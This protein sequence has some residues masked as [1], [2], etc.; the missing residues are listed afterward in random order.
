[1]KVLFASS[2]IFPYAKSGG[3]ADVADA[4]PRALSSYTELYSVIPLYG[5]MSK[6]DL[7]LSQS[8][9]VSLGD[10]KYKI[11][12]SFED[13]IRDGNRT[14]LQDVRALWAIWT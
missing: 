12:N 7:E 11:N 10:E 14:F 3:L 1:M 5:F 4:L 8:F 13:E 2:E 9:E 6:K